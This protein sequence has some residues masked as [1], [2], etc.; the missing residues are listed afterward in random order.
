MYVAISLGI[1]VFAGFGLSTLLCITAVFVVWALYYFM[2][3]LWPRE[4]FVGLW[5]S[6]IGVG[7]GVGATIGWLSTDVVPRARSLP[8]LGWL[9]VGTASAWAAFYYKSVIDPN[10]A[11]FSST[12]VSLTAIMWAILVPNILAS[13]V[14]L[15]RQVMKGT[16]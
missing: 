3:F 1:R 8:T 5:F 14:G 7:G 9:A 2:D 10:P 4:V 16:V 6:M 12:E 15:V 11:A 13:G